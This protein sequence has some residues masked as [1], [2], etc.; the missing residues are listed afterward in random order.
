MRVWA[1]PVSRSTP[2]WARSWSLVMVS[3]S[4]GSRL[5]VMMVAAARA[6]RSTTSS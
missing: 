1:R 5:L 2:A 3:H 6:W 4:L